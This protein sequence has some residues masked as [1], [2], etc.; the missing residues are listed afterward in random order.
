MKNEA[1]C[2][3]ILLGGAS[4][5]SVVYCADCDVA[6]MELGAMSMRIKSDDLF[7]LQALLAQ[8]CSQ[9]AALKAGKH[10]ENLLTDL[11]H[12]RVDLH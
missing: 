2:R 1:S 4:G 9:L 12:E 5:C 6:E 10:L 8:A 3:R 11:D 7:D